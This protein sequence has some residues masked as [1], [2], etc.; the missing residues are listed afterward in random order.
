MLQPFVADHPFPKKR[1]RLAIVGILL[2]FTGRP[3]RGCRFESSL[4]RQA[5]RERNSRLGPDN[6][7]KPPFRSRQRFP[8]QNPPTGSTLLSGGPARGRR[9]EERYESRGP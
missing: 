8:A 3:R 6:G 7:T 5:L 9:Q 2:G 1:S 4:R